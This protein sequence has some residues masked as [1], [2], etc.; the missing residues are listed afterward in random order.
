MIYGAVSDV[1]NIIQFPSFFQFFG[2][3][4]ESA[5][6]GDLYIQ[7]NELKI[8]K[9]VRKSKETHGLGKTSYEI[10]LTPSSLLLSIPLIK[11]EKKRK[12]LG[13]LTRQF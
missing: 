3:C 7:K 12:H 11:T 10:L 8:T 9:W 2:W 4:S 13:F 1:N 6:V 5:G